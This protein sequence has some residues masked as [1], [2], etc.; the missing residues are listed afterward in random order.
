MQHILYYFLAIVNLSDIFKKLAMIKIYFPS[1]SN[2][3][4]IL[5]IALLTFPYT[6]YSQEDV[7]ITNNLGI[8]EA[9][10]RGDMEKVRH[11]LELKPALL[12]SGDKIGHTPLSISAIYARWDIFMYLMQLGADLNS[13]TQTNTTVLH[14]VCQHDRPD[15]V[16]VVLE[17]GGRNL[18]RIR[19]VYGEYSPMLRAVQSGCKNTVEF[20]MNN[21]ASED[22]MTTEGWNALH[23]A[24]KCG[25][26]HLYDMLK[27]N[28]VSESAIDNKGKKPM[29]YDFK[30]PEPVCI[31]SESLK[32]YTGR[33][34]WEGAPEGF[35]ITV[36]IDDSVLILDDYSL[37]ELYPIN[38]D[39][40]YCTQNP[41]EVLF[42]RD[43]SGDISGV[44]LT[45]LRRKVSL[46]KMD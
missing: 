4:L 41:W 5:L 18:L 20:L 37:N 17:K 26:R 16:A 6:L 30:R 10:R 29:D 8:H 33:Y 35:Y 7:I 45:F 11:I 15:M 43:S 22:E 36:F 3:P 9:V 21:G 28:G 1:N 13:I 27:E 19:D 40:F 31:G 25:H 32:Q 38:K 24:A 14:A 34:T 2:K 23:L 12:N 46:I 42:I 44:N 39:T